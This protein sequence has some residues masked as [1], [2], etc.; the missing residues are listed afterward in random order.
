MFN[1]RLSQTRQIIENTFG[2]LAARYVY[3]CNDSMFKCNHMV[4]TLV[5]VGGRSSGG[6][7]LPNLNGYLFT[8]RPP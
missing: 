7:L 5:C 4:G 2:I 3:G 6:P 8:P 1:Y